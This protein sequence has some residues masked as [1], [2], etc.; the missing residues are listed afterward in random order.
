MTKEKII[1][2][3]ESLAPTLEVIQDILSLPTK[4]YGND[5]NPYEIR[6]GLNSVVLKEENY[7]FTTVWI[8][9]SERVDLEEGLRDCIEQLINHWKNEI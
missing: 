2:K 4:K 3:F 5:F 8:A 6:L 7:V 9:K 1:E